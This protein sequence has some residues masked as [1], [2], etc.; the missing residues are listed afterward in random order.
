MYM[1]EMVDD[2][3]NSNVERHDVFSNLV[4]ANDENV[5]KSGLTKSEIIGACCLSWTNVIRTLNLNLAVFKE[6]SICFCWRA[7]KYV[8]W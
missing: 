1:S 4:A 7:T 6:I 8:F 3:Q 2:R 5:D